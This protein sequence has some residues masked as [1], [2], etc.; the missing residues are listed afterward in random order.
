[1]AKFLVPLDLNKLDLKDYLYHAYNIPV[2]AVR[3]YI[4]QQKIRQGKMSD[5]WFK[6]RQWSRPRAIKH[7]IVEMKDP[8]VWP[9]ETRDLQEWDQKSFKG[10]QEAQEQYS[11]ERQ[12][13]QRAVRTDQRTLREQAQALLEGREKWK[14]SWETFK[15]KTG[16]VFKRSGE[17]L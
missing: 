7:M 5:K 8:F 16:Q 1:M 6:Q 12:L 9:E 10:A 15:P 14:P 3:S 13:Q 2:L 4:T 11:L 17:K